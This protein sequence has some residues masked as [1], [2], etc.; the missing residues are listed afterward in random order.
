MLHTRKFVSVAAVSGLL[1]VGGCSDPKTGNATSA[2]PTA[3]TSARLPSNGAP[4]VTNPILNTAQA[5]SDPCSTVATAQIEELGGKVEKTEVDDGT[6]GKSC[7]WIF[8]A[9]PSSVTAG[10]LPGNKDGLSSLYAK[11]AQGGLSTFKPI[12]SIE[13][14][15]GVIYDNGGEGKGRCVLA[16]GVR[17]DLTYTVTPLLATGNPMLS[18][19]CGLATKVAAAAIKKLKGA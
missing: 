12:D 16:V 19:P 13:G 7:G 3:P 8:E 9:G 15:P 11:H 14:Y 18:D 1:L 4:A 2:A 5:E 17:D 10:L 6:F